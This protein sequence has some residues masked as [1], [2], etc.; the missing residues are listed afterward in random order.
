[1]PKAMWGI[2]SK[3]RFDFRSQLTK[4]TLPDVDKEGSKVVISVQMHEIRKATKMGL[5]C[6]RLVRRFYRQT[7]YLCC[8]EL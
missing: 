7:H 4:R 6:L 8:P 1:M 3:S 2:K 5:I